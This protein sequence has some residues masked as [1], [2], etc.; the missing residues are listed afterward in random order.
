MHQPL[1][2]AI[3]WGFL[4]VLTLPFPILLATDGLAWGL[5]MLVG[6]GLAWTDMFAERLLLQHRLHEHGLVFRS[7]PGLRTY[8]V[9]HGSQ[10]VTPY[11]RWPQGARPVD[12]T[13]T[14]E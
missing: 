3:G 5:G 8:V 12:R 6:L 7:I 11:R 14:G 9:V 2:P 10:Q 1:H 13:V 4:A